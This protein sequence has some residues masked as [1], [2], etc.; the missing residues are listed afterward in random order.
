MQITVTTLSDQIFTLDVSDDLEL[1]NFKALCEFEIGIPAREI[2]ITWNGKPIQDDKRS[3]SSYGIK[4]GDMLLLQ[5]NRGSQGLQQSMPRQGGFDIDF[6]SVPIP[7]TSQQSVARNQPPDP[8]D[9]AYI[10]ELL[11]KNPHELSLLRERNPE[12]A[13]ALINGTFEKFKDVLQ[14]QTRERKEKE[15]ERIQLMNADPF[16]AEAQKMIAEEIRMKNVESNMETSIEYSPESFGQVVMLYIDCVVNGHHVKAFV[17]SGAQMTIMSEACAERCN[18]MRLV[19]RRWGGIAKG[20]GTQQIIG[21][22]HLGQIQI[23]KDYLQSSFSILKD[24]PMDML[25]GLDML[26]RHQCCIDLKR[27]LLVIGTT[28][29]E[30]RFLDE[31]DLPGHARLN[32]GPMSPKAAEEEDKLLAEAIHKSQTEHQG[33]AGASSNTNTNSSSNTPPSFPE[34][35]I[36][37]LMDLGFPRE[38]VIHELTLANG[39]SQQAMGA[40]FAKSLKVPDGPK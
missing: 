9:P 18:I 2:G 30:T 34:Q 33:T 26:K 3:L 13:E 17:D 20:V 1:E 21:R 8:E 29:T 28:G 35:V 4:H 38:A 23:G 32:V 6:G 11:L 24:Q 31:T 25:L 12:L 14:R 27:N 37:P 10:R 19:D 5:H 15:M 22:V 7:G 16:S 36:K 40:L 39:N